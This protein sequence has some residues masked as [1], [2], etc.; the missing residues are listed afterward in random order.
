L[1]YLLEETQE[2]AKASRAACTPDFSL[3]VKDQ[4]LVYQREQMDDFPP[5]N[6]TSLTAGRSTCVCRPVSSHQEASIGGSKLPFLDF[7]KGLC[8]ERGKSMPAP[9]STNPRRCAKY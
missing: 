7:P 1:P 5:G 3:F 2:V 6:G 4:R 8:S 9:T